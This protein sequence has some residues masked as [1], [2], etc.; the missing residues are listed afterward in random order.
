MRADARKN[1]DHLLAIAD[2]VI[3]EQGADVSMRDLARRAEVGLA[4]LLR[5]FPTRDA[6]LDALLRAGFDELTA[7]ADRLEARLPPGEALKAWLRDFVA[8]AHTYRGAVTTMM[9]A[10]EDPDSALHASCVA[11][12]GSGARLLER[13]Q[14]AGQAR[15][16]LTGPDLFALGGAL[17][18]LHD[19]P[20]S[21]PRADHLLDVV[22]AAIL[23]PQKP[24]ARPRERGRAHGEGPTHSAS[25]HSG[26]TGPTPLP[27][28]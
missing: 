24:Q 16:D 10:I 22:V 15:T 20:T 12:R 2:A 8:C 13:A 25:R 23:T 18:W 11:M 14:S 1:R 7:L 5:H 26:D 6:L 4:T 9:G 3:T 17:I 28:G 27:S 19:Q 21:A